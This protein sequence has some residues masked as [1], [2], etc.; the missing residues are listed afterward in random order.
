MAGLLSHLD[1]VN[2]IFHN[3]YNVKMFF[4]YPFSKTPTSKRSVGGEYDKKANGKA[5]DG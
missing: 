5:L 2:I 4:V 3:L 1:T